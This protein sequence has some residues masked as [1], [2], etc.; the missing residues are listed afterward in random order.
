MIAEGSAKLASVPSGGSGAAAA[1]GGAAAA[2]GATE[3]AK[4]EE[5][6]EGTHSLFARHILRT[7][8]TPIQRRRSPMTTWDSVCSTKRF[9][10]QPNIPPTAEKYLEELGQYVQCEAVCNSFSLPNTRELDLQGYVFKGN[11]RPQIVGQPKI[12]VF[13]GVL[14]SIFAHN[15]DCDT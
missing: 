5:K 3:D 1:S 13:P 2:G 9:I 11:G 6:V 10:S 14:K 15:S 7:S 8:L 12:Q 4:V